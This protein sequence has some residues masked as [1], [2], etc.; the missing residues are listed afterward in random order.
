[1]DD[2]YYT[3][4]DEIESL[5]L[6]LVYVACDGAVAWKKG[7]NLETVLALKLY[8]L[9]YNFEHQLSYAPLE[10]HAPL[11]A[12]HSCYRNGDIGEVIS[13]FNTQLFFSP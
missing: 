10:F 5:F 1:M 6:T 9:N 8:T 7:L 3:I 2:T 4:K 13:L 12:F 11:K